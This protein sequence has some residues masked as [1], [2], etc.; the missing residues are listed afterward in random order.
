MKSVKKFNQFKQS[1]KKKFLKLNGKLFVIKPFEESDESNI[2]DR[3]SECY[4]LP[5]EVCK[6]FVS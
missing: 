5:E 1:L 6:M 2:I 3:I 4:F